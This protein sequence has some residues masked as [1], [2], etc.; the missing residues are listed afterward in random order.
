[1]SMTRRQRIAL[2]TGLAIVGVYFL[3]KIA[4]V[5]II[6]YKMSKQ[7]KIPPSPVEIAKVTAENWQDK[8]SS[9]G[10]ISAI[11]GVTISAE[12]A[13]RVTKIYFK[14]GADVKKGEPLFQIYPDVLEAELQNDQAALALA[15]VNYDRAA[16]LYLKR[17]A[18]KEQLDQYT[19]QLQQAQANVNETKANLVLHNIVAPFSGRIGL[20]TVDVG[21]Y[22]NVGDQLVSLQQ[23]NPLRI[24]FY[25]PDRYIDKL[26]IG[27]KVDV[28]P[29]SSAESVVYVGQVYAFNS[30]VET[31]TRTFS[32]WAK[33]PNPGETLIPGTYVNVDVYIGQP[34]QVLTIP[35][36][37]ALYS[38]Q[39]DYVFKVVDGKAVKTPAVFGQRQ[40]NWIEVKSGLKV[41]DV[42]IT[43]GQLRVFDGAQIQIAPTSTYPESQPPA[44]KYIRF[45]NAQAE[46]EGEEV[47][48]VSPTTRVVTPKNNSPT[49]NANNNNANGNNKGL[50][51]S[52]SG[53]TTNSNTSTSGNAPTSSNTPTS[54]NMP[55]SDNASGN[56]STSDKVPTSI[57]STTSPVTTP[58]NPGTTV[59][60][61]TSQSLVRPTTTTT[62]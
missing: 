49:G 28:M 8:I 5:L 60:P 14:S 51:G 62:Q 4:K 15:Q 33:I 1:M 11:K 48:T 56:A 23:M 7:P 2:Y 32:M 26:A 50:T 6:D 19:A 46:Q 35:Q 43:A 42:V 13:G 58:S 18:S 52:S 39:G 29:S 37:A 53:S 24:D 34:H 31:D 25:V 45:P 41:N 12:V 17:V 36:T 27:D 3:I 61:D 16:A 55:A 38:P 47:D 59:A 9:T 20:K 57:K 54:S 22:V 40:H 30:I 21:D 44:I 10:T